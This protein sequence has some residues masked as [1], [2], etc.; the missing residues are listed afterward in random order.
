[1]TQPPH[2]VTG[3]TPSAGVDALRD[4]DLQLALHVA[5][6]LHYRSFEDVADGWE[7]EPHLI[8][9]RRS[10]EDEFLAALF[11]AVGGPRVC[12]PRDVADQLQAIINSGTGPSLSTF[13]ATEGTIDHVREFAV[14]RSA[15]QLK[16]A[17]PH[18]WG[19]PR[20][21]GSPKAA[22]VLIQADEYGNGRPAGMHATLFGRTMDAL[23]LDSNYGAYLNNI[24][25]LTLATGNLISFFGL[26]RRWRGALV[27]HLAVFEMTSVV[28]M[29][30]YASALRRLGF[31]PDATDFYDVH[32]EADEVHQH[33]AAH[34]LA[35]GFAS[36]EPDRTGDILFGAR[37]LMA[38]EETFARHLLAAWS[39]DATSLRSPLS[40]GA[41]RAA[42]LASYA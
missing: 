29:G 28:P 34:D 10:L 11:D 25:G 9:F 39:A 13:M 22:L 24:P 3:P 30:R 12:A 15:Y 23:G 21:A 38:V 36:Y 35:T 17:D 41:T 2:P 20:L 1:L 31:G 6:E 16:E 26:H 18:T 33:V 4:E 40:G 42:R 27:G 19:I 32:V 37:A 5:Y 7:W 8:A 14:H